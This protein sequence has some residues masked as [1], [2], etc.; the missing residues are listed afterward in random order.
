MRQERAKSKNKRPIDQSHVALIL[1]FT[2]PLRHG[3]YSAGVIVCVWE[4]VYGINRLHSN[5]ST[6][7]NRICFAFN[8]IGFMNF[9]FGWR[10]TSFEWI[11]RARETKTKIQ[12]HTYIF[13]ISLF[14]F[15]FVFVVRSPSLRS[16]SAYESE[17]HWQWHR[18]SLL[19]THE[20]TYLTV[21][22]FVH[23]NVEFT[24]KTNEP[25]W[26]RTAVSVDNLALIRS[27]T[28][29][30]AKCTEPFECRRFS[31]IYIADTVTPTH[32]R[33]EWECCRFICP[34]KFQHMRIDTFIPNKY[35]H[36]SDVK[37]GFCLFLL[38]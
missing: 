18:A 6:Q 37:F 32:G 26:H 25:M 33:N 5:I 28:R 13:L 20:T 34:K 29:S 22:I 7:I 24:H 27:T 19:F 17:F 4:S 8:S 30:N 36:I 31:Y 16:G 3:S 23:S 14:S 21:R 11:A 38:N 10:Q 35:L 12:N 15:S 1:R 9:S 2:Q